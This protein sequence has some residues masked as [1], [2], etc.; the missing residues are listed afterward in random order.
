[1]RAVLRVRLRAVVLY[2]KGV[3]KVSC[4]FR[5]IL[6][7][8]GTGKAVLCV[9]ACRE[10]Y[11]SVY[12]ENWRHFETK[13]LLCK[14]YVLHCLVHH[15]QCCCVTLIFQYNTNVWCFWFL[16]DEP[17]VSIPEC[18]SDWLGLRWVISVWCALCCCLICLDSWTRNKTVGHS[19]KLYLCVLSNVQHFSAWLISRHRVRIK[20]VWTLVCNP[21]KTLE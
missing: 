15:L 18:E 8:F 9:W 2:L 19:Y 11:I 14:M 4:V 3:N 10:L 21:P 5:P 16:H 6:M 7:K 17:A 12:R 1:M 20:F 13:E